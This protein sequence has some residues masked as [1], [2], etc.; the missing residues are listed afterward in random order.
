M[1]F[2]F[3]G[4]ETISICLWSE[5]NGNL[6][7]VLLEI[8]NEILLHI[9]QTL[10][11]SVYAPD[12]CVTQVLLLLQHST[13]PQSLLHVG[14]L[15]LFTIPFLLFDGI[16]SWWINIIKSSLV[17]FITLINI[18]TVKQNILRFIFEWIFNPIGQEKLHWNC[19]KCNENIGKCLWK[20]LVLS[21]WWWETLGRISL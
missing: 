18:Y 21:C 13:P 10:L 6:L 2:T 5:N 8:W 7:H 9:F 17:H 1:Y 4:G 16:F 14:L 12:K 19:E 15:L 20:D 3:P 11:K